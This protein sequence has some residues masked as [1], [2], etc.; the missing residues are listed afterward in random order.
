MN[1]LPK[2]S[3]DVD[4]RFR[5]AELFIQYVCKHRLYFL[6]KLFGPY[7]T[8]LLAGNKIT[9]L[10][11]DED[12]HLFTGIKTYRELENI[13]FMTVKAIGGVT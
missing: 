13:D 12:F 8:E 4:V 11:P 3:K 9:F 10:F 5:Y 6:E 7:E 2:K 1:T